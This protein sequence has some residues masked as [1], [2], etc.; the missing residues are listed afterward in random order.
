M[1]IKGITIS[2]RIVTIECKRLRPVVVMGKAMVAAERGRWGYPDV[3]FYPDS[4][5]VEE[6]EKPN[7]DNG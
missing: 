4:Y 1:K 7:E 5:M 6:G 2:G 3:L